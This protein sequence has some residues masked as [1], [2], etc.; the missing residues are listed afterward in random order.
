[1]PEIPEIAKAVA[2]I[3]IELIEYIPNS[4]VSRTIIKK[5]TGN[6]TAMSLDTGEGLTEKIMPFDSFAQ[7]IDGKAEIIIDGKPHLLNMGE[8]IV[9]PA[10]RSHSINA[11]ERF[12]MI[13]TIIKSGYEDTRDL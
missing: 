3:I 10:H 6:V 4:V 11:N 9:I 1:M 13:L 12:K 7:I 2:H 8:G 5:T